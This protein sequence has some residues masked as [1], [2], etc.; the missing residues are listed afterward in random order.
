MTL[1]LE[2]IFKLL[3]SLVLGG[4]VGFEREFKSR[5][6][7][8][9]THIL[10][11]IGAAL[12]QIT[13][14]NYFRSNGL[15]NMDPMRLGA[16]VIS[17]IG[18]LGAGTILKEGANIKGLTTAASIWV[19]GCIGIAVGTGLYIEATAATILIY[20]ALR[21][22][23][24]IEDNMAKGKKYINIEI[25]AK[26]TPGMIG[27]IGNLFGELEISIENIEMSDNDEEQV[28][29]FLTLKLKHL[30]PIQMLVEDL[31]KIEDIHK[32]KQQ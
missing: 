7:G 17:G 6:A 9:R 22:F 21:G 4:I 8:L 31:L 13:A 23:K 19:V 32:V 20:V 29:I 12:V 10:V 30:I 26:N 5:P 2:M 25:T 16:Q 15:P 27:K 28:V 1:Y 24:I 3:L 14:L 11:C 18:F